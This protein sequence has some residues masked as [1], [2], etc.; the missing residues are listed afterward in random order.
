MKSLGNSSQRWGSVSKTFHWLIALLIFCMM[1]L[2]WV[3]VNWP[4]SPEKLELFNWHKSLGVTILT[5]VVLRLIWR[6]CNTTPTLPDHITALQSCVAKFNHWLLYSL[7]L[8]MP[9]SGWVINSAANFPLK[10]FGFVRVPNI[11][12]VDKQLQTQAEI[13]HLSLFW[14]FLLLIVLHIAAALKHHYADKDNVLRRMLPH[15]E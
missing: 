9:V 12:P 4:L 1:M 2:G 13:I 8:A 6:L 11:A 14:I 7:M 10:W 5:L 3:M 15:W